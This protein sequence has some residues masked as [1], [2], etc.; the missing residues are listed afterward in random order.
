MYK[1]GIQIPDYGDD[2]VKGQSTLTK[3]YDSN[4]F[5]KN[6]NLTITFLLRDQLA[7]ENIVTVTR[8]LKE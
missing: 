8:D 6:E 5:I 3:S 7:S 2:L 1:D 4:T